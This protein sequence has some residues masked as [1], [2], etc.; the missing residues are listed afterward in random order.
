MS[1]AE[2]DVT[3]IGQRLTHSRWASTKPSGWPESAE[4]LRA[5]MARRL[6]VSTKCRRQRRSLRP[7]LRAQPR[8]EEH[9]N[10]A[11]HATL[12]LPAYPGFCG[13]PSTTAH[14][15]LPP[16]EAV[17]P[18]TQRFCELDRRERIGLPDP[19]RSMFYFAGRPARYQRKFEREL[20]WGSEPNAGANSLLH[21]LTEGSGLA[22]DL[23]RGSEVARA[24]ARQ[25][26]HGGRGGRVNQG[27]PGSRPNYGV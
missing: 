20:L 22:P 7:D 13:A 19:A 27:S 15:K 12:C 14:P 17:A 24:G 2:E 3:S 6:P 16:P 4:S 9:H 1:D 26:T 23:R 10:P 8:G 5:R 18:R 21:R 25:R 11:R